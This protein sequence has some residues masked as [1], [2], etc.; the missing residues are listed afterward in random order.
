[1]LVPPDTSA[2]HGRGAGR[3]HLGL[4]IELRPKAR[5]TRKKAEIEMAMAQTERA[6]G[7]E[8]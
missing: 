3:G 5:Q 8:L 4:C 2:C 6:L 1:V 7:V